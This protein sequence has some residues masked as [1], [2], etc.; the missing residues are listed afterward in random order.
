MAIH[1]VTR[2]LKIAALARSLGDDDTNKTLP[3]TR[4]LSVV[5][6]KTAAPH[7]EAL[8][9]L[10]FKVEFQFACHYFVDTI[11][12]AHMGRTKAQAEHQESQA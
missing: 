11:Y 6:A 5:V 7:Q 9:W 10:S 4:L 2:A 3:A 8:T 12:Y 1:H